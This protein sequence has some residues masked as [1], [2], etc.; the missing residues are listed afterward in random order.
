METIISTLASVDTVM[1]DM[2][3]NPYVSAALMI[4][5][6]VYAGLLAPA[7]PGKVAKLFDYSVFRILV[8]C[9][10]LIINRYNSAVAL[11]VAIAFFLT[12]QALSKARL[13]SF[14]DQVTHYKRM[15]TGQKEEQLAPAQA[16]AH[17]NQQAQAI[18]QAQAQSQTDQEEV[19][20]VKTTANDTP[21]NTEVSGLANRT[22]EFESAQGLGGLHGFDGNI[23]GA[24]FSE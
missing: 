11:I 14:M 9:A 7:L 8:L 13:A 6:I 4:F 12:L 15:V 17:A 3:A 1:Q 10:I 2:Y 23:V 19:L 16:Q 18:A 22:Q 5:F 24:E 21:D 20:M